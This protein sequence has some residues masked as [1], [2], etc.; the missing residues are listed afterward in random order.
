MQ[1]ER[2]VVYLVGAGPGD[3][4]LLTLR[5]RD[6]LRQAD[7]VIYD[8][9]LHPQIL[10]HVPVQAERLFVG[11]K[12]GAQ[13]YGQ[14]AINALIIQ[15]AQPHRVVVRLK[16]GDPFCFGRGGEEARALKKAGVSFRVVPGVTSGIAAPAYA[17]IPVTDRESAPSVC[18]MTGTEKPGNDRHDWQAL[19]K[20][21]TLVI[22]MGVG[23]FPSI[24]T[25]L[26]ANGK[27]PH[28]PVAAIRWGTWSHQQI[29]T[30][31]LENFTQRLSDRKF[32]APAII[33]IGEVA[34]NHE[35]LDWCQLGPLSGRTMVVAGLQRQDPLTLALEDNGARVI[36]CP[37]DPVLL[38]N[39]N[40]IFPH[41]FEE[42]ETLVFTARAAV[43]FFM[44]IVLRD[45]SDIRQ[46]SGKKIA[47]IGPSCADELSKYHIK[48]D[49]IPKIHD[50]QHLLQV[51]VEQTKPGVVWHPCSEGSNWQGVRVL[52]EA[53]YKTYTIP[54]Y[55]QQARSSVM[56][57]TGEKVDAVCMSSP[58]AVRRY[59]AYMD[60]EDH[61]ELMKEEVHFFAIGSATQRLMKEQGIPVSSV[62]P[63]STTESL[64]DTIC[65]HYAPSSSI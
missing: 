4:G 52:E 30:G 16:G 58:S 56:R 3:P 12:G 38:P 60:A 53:G 49:I 28:T 59:L 9:L 6:I 63:E 26:L 51:I 7:C 36:H 13:A 43:R 45:K 50:T 19:A 46:F 47:A 25:S 48:P 62:A 54:L 23:Q 18:F 27:N 32:G 8:Y 20:L 15:H 42:V 65:A 1:V 37:G 41:S 61:Q 40:I 35:E 17:G 55:R 11:K 10:D 5:A 57:L 39:P 2:G 29:L 24:C 33:V 22:Y 21:P 14:E 44:D 31:T 34:S 64:V